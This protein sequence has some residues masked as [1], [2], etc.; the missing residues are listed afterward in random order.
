[1]R[2]RDREIEEKLN[3]KL[4]SK[5]KQLNLIEYILVEYSKQTEQTSCT[6]NS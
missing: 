2:E 3:D 6:T 5:K 4:F 1:M